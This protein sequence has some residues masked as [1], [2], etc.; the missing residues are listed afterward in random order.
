MALPYWGWD[1]GAVAGQ[2]F[3]AVIARRFATLRDD[4]IPPELG[5]E[6]SLSNGYQLLTNDAALASRMRSMRVGGRE[7]GGRGLGAGTCSTGDACV[8]VCVQVGEQVQKA[9]AQWEHARAASTGG[10]NPDSTETP[11]NSMWARAEAGR[12]GGTRQL[13]AWSGRR[14]A[15]SCGVHAAPSAPPLSAG[16]WRWAGP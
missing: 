9:L 15:V 4:L 7:K 8:R 1:R 13:L 16:T 6:L 2:L 12:G 14:G 11:H 3:P 5:A 10:G